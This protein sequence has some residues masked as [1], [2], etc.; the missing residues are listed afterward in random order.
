MSPELFKE[1]TGEYEIQPGFS[2]TVFLENG[3]FMTQ[4]TGQSKFEIFPSSKT[5]FFLKVVEAEIEFIRNEDDVVDSLI[6]YQGGQEILG[7]KK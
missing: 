6:L 4:A 5:R 7:K 1:Y 2:L 3:H